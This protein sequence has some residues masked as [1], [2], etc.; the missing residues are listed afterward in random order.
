[1]TTVEEYGRIKQGH[2][3]RQ[4]DPR[5]FHTWWQRSEPPRTA[6]TASGE[7]SVLSSC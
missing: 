7:E 3:G 6:A 2:E 5:C 1:M 4:E